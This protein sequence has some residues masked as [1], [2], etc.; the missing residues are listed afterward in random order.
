M[1][2]DV[3]RYNHHRIFDASSDICCFE[4]PRIGRC[5]MHRGHGEDPGLVGVGMQPRRLSRT[6]CYFWHST[7][8]RGCAPDR[9]SEKPDSAADAADKSYI[10]A[11]NP[12]VI[13]DRRLPDAHL[14]YFVDA[15]S[16]STITLLARKVRVTYRNITVRP[17]ELQ[18][19]PTGLA[20]R[21]RRLSPAISLHL[22]LAISYHRYTIPL[23][24]AAS[25]TCITPESSYDRRGPDKQSLIA[26][27]HSSSWRR[28]LSSRTSFQ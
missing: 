12:T 7:S 5:Q 24:T 10:L 2:A 21:L 26:Q 9:A 14:I 4:G 20:K 17:K 3:L 13:L 1:S 11:R 27:L 22:R 18:G 23:S 19:A 28:R 25:A 16:L 6:D 15:A 8:G